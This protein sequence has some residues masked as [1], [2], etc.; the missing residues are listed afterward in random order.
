MIILVDADS[1]IYSACCGVDDEINE[2]IGKFDQVYMSIISYLEEC[3]EVEKV[4][5][6]AN[7][8]GNYRKIISKT[9]K[10][11]RT[12]PKPKLWKELKEIIVDQYS[13]KQ[14]FAMETDDL[15]ASYWR[16]LSKEHGRENVMIVS[17]DKDY[18]QL[19]AL[20][21]NYHSNH[22][23]VYDISKESARFNFYASMI[24]GDPADNVNYCKGYGIKYAQKVLKDCKTKY[25]YTKQVFS[26]FKKIHKQKAR[27][28]YIECYNLLG[29]AL[30][31]K[32]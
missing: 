32:D 13:M 28:R 1:L 14:A 26:L 21:Y 16:R 25:E 22:Q 19:P 15:V 20:I 24:T 10:A 29:L 31:E 17:L 12:K 8:K 30:W 11:N 2:A 9:Y 5:G 7:A 3:F 23:C 27:E 6:F 18:K 4:I